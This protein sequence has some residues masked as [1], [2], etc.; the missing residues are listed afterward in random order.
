M[1]DAPQIQPFDPAAAG[2]EPYPG[3]G[4]IG[5]GRPVLTRQDGEKHLFAFMA[6]KKHHNAAAWCRAAC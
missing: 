4:F 1:N 3:E 6:E 5:L 2:W